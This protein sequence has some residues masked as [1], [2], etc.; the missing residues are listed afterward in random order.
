M[1]QLPT[2]PPVSPVPE[3]PATPPVLPPTPPVTDTP[4]AT[5]TP[6]AA[7]TPPPPARSNSLKTVGLITGIVAVLGVAAFFAWNYIQKSVQTSLTPSTSQAPTMP[8]PTLQSGKLVVG[9][10]A[11]FEPMEFRDKEGK[12]I[13]Y[14]VDLGDRI[15]QQLGIKAEFRH[16]DWDD[17]FVALE[18]KEIDVIISSVTINDERKEKYNFSAAYLNAGQVIITQKTNTTISATKDLAGKKIA[19]QKN[20]TNEEQALKF[21]S[22]NLVLRFDDYE[23]ATKALLDGQADAIFSDLTVAKGIIT[24]NDTLRIASEPFTSEYYGIVFRK[25]D[26]E[27]LGRVDEALDTLRQQGV[28]VYLKQKWLE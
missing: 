13:G 23:G 5:T 27:L 16:Y 28:L 18:N 9:L 24:E 1:D 26:T 3:Q 7:P 8:P 2:Q 6:P 19:V 12:F 17:L 20:T 4:P 25:T 14:D 10:E 22:E 21:T 15:A 11:A